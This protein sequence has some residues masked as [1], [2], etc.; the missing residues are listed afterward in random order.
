M[1]F[2]M[3]LWFTTGIAFWV[4][5]IIWG[6]NRIKNRESK[7]TGKIP[8]IL[9]AVSVLSLI[10]GASLTPS[11]NDDKQADVS[12]STSKKSVSKTASEKDSLKQ[13]TL[14]SASKVSSKAAAK[15]S[16]KAASSKAAS[17]SEAKESSERATSASIAH[18]PATYQTGITYDQVAR[19]PD[20]YDMKKVQFTGRVLQVME[21]K[22]ETQIRLGVDGSYDNVI[23]V[24]IDKSDL[25]GSRILED[26]LV[27]VSGV[28]SNTVSY[29]S[30]LGGNITIPSMIGLIVDDQGPA[31]DDYGY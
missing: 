17:E 21:D 29:E 27:T 23:L 28:S 6:I 24:S 12:S 25:N 31:S 3:I 26:D 5:L 20:E 11:D 22:T 18:D 16:S 13:A 1:T 7:I 30:T 8:L 15:A 10:I 4:T 19:T 14:E 9:L 2:L